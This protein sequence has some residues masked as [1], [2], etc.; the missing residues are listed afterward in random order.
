MDSDEMREFLAR[1]DLER[2]TF[3][4]KQTGNP[5]YVWDARQTCR[6]GGIQTPEWIENYLDEVTTSLLNVRD[7]EDGFGPERVADALDL[8]TRGGPSRFKQYEKSEQRRSAIALIW[9]MRDRHQNEKAFRREL[10][11]IDK[12]ESCGQLSKKSANGRR[13]WMCRFYKR[14]SDLEIFE[15][16]AEYLNNRGT[17]VET[18][19]AKTILNWWYDY[20]S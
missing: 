7:S 3:M 19:D 15:D 9:A 11:K 1:G 17:P 18:V 12:G 6:Q 20:G 8:K 5:L 14:K 10:D 13:E 4:Y 2:E 16:V